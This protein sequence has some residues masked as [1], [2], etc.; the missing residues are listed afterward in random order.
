LTIL[1]YLLITAYSNGGA[2]FLVPY[3]IVLYIIGKPGYFL[4]MIV[5]QFS[6]RGTIKVYDCS[7]AMRGVGTGQVLSSIFVATYYSSIMGL[8]LK[9]L[10]DSFSFDLPWASCRPE[11]GSDC[12]SA[13]LNNE[14]ARVNVSSKIFSSPAKLYF[15]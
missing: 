14:S 15:E 2:A 6:S 8:T 5:G 9:Y 3:I 4:E 7:P 13:A 12:F 10:F 1:I 11:W